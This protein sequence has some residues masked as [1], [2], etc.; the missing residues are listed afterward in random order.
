MTSAPATLRRGAPQD[1]PAHFEPHIQGLRA[2]AVALVVLYH[3]WP[4]RVTGGYLGVDV[5]FVISGYLITG[6]LVRQLDAGGAAGFHRIRLADFWAKRIRRLL[7]AAILVLVVCAILMITLMPLSALP[8]TFRQIVASSLYY[9]N[10][11]LVLNSADYLQ[12]S[13]QTIV[14]HYWSLSVEEQFYVV[15]PLLL[16]LVAWLGWRS[17]IPRDGTLAFVAGTG[18]DPQVARRRA[19]LWTVLAVTVAGYLVCGLYTEAQSGAAYFATFTRMWEFGVGALVTLLPR[20]RPASKWM[21]AVLGWAGILLILVPGLV[22]FDEET[23]FPGWVAAVPVIGTAIAIAAARA[24][25]WWLPARWLSFRPVRWV[26]DVSYSLYLWHWPLIIVAPYI[27]GWSLEWYNRV[28]LIVV[29]V[30][31]A[32]ATKRLVED[33]FR[34]WRRLGHAHVAQTFL[35]AVAMMLVSVLA[36]TGVNAVLGPQYDAQA[37]QL[38]QTVANPPPCFGAAAAIAPC[39]NP[40]LVD[41]IIPSPGFADADGPSQYQCFTQ[42]NNSVANPCHF[43]S[44]DP[45]AMKVALVGDSHAFQYSDLLISLAETNGWSLTIVTKGACPWSTMH[46]ESSSAAFG[47]ACDAYQANE[48]AALQAAGP[49]DAVVTTALIETKFWSHGEA[50]RATAATGYEQAWAALGAPI[51]AIRDNPRFEDDPNKCLKQTGKAS[52]CTSP[53]DFALDGDDPIAIAATAS[54]AQLID[55]TDTYCDAEACRSVVGGASI[56]R[57]RDHMTD[58]WISTMSPLIESAI[59]AAAATGR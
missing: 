9:E 54:G 17:R 45:G 43:G 33:P 23:A 37:A 31:L 10:W 20:W 3:V 24:D 51:V 34:S 35:A 55:L 2:I 6:Q 49:F 56:Y 19:V 53:R 15:W 22:A 46:I 40:E 39:S 8:E 1:R 47:A 27:P 12:N 52:A 5:F 44:D 57:D 13:D 38:K 14:Q 59:T 48:A 16:L 7:P 29:A 32:W 30:L 36:I 28:A 18:R 41:T 50:D 42:L 11:A 4:G 21:N 25:A 58:T 26:G